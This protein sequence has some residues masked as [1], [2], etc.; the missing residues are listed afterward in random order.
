MA[1]SGPETISGKRLKNDERCFLFHLEIC[2]SQGLPE[3]IKTTVLTTC[4]LLIYIVISKYKE[5]WN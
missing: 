5:V 1:T 3:Y 4:F 2:P